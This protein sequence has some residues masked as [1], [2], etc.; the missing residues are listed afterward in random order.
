M[1]DGGNTNTNEMKLIVN[2]ESVNVV[3]GS[4]DALLGHARSHG[5]LHTA[6]IR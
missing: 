3:N 1:H 6:L 2:K 5:C 4:C